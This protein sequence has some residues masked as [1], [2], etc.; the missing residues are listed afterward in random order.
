MPQR[1]GRSQ[2]LPALRPHT[3]ELGSLG[4]FGRP[5]V[6]ITDGIS[7]LNRSAIEC[8]DAIQAVEVAEQLATSI[9]PDHLRLINEESVVIV[10]DDADNEVSRIKIKPRLRPLV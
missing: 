4:S 10:H 9:S 6:A 1:S 3:E 2:P 8:K 5:L 7:V